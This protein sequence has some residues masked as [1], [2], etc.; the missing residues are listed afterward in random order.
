MADSARI[1]CFTAGSVWKACRMTRSQNGASTYRSQSEPEKT[2]TTNR[3]KTDRHTSASHGAASEELKVPLLQFVAERPVHQHHAKQAASA[4]RL[5][6]PM[7]LPLAGLEKL[8]AA[9]REDRVAIACAA[10]GETLCAGRPRLVAF[11]LAYAARQAP[12]S[13]EST[14]RPP[15]RCCFELHFKVHVFYPTSSKV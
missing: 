9:K 1:A 11:D 5:P 12:R 4:G 10:G 8:C 2:C 3:A 13:A 14:Q 7:T 6:R 15:L